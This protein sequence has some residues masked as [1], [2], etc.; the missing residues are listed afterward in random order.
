MTKP[1]VPLNHHECAFLRRRGPL[2]HS[3][4]IHQKLTDAYEGR[5]FHPWYQPQVPSSRYALRRKLLI[6]SLRIR[7]FQAWAWLD[8]RWMVFRYGRYRPEAPTR[9]SPP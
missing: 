3:Q 7:F 4:I 9:P 1:Y 2:L 6:L 5:W 8:V